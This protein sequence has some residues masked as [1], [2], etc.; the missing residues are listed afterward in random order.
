M[1]NIKELSY[2]AVEKVVVHLPSGDILLDKN[3]VYEVR[4]CQ[5]E[6]CSPDNA[7]DIICALQFIDDSGIP[8]LRFENK[9]KK[10]F[11][12]Q[13]YISDGEMYLI[14]KNNDNDNFGFTL[15]QSYAELVLEV[16]QTDEGI[17]IKNNA[18]APLIMCDMVGPKKNVLLCLGECIISE[19]KTLV[20]FDCEAP[21]N[22]S[23]ENDWW[24][25]WD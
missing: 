9:D 3:A 25:T 11:L 24:P 19:K 12:Y 6:E 15:E 1:P 17:Y 23:E 4:R 7:L 18:F 10:E 22:D 14:Q 16:F 21:K 2:E 13:H 20:S 5:I 8:K